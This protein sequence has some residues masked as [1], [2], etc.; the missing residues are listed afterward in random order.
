[1]NF[2]GGEIDAKREMLLL[3]FHLTNFD[4]ITQQGMSINDFE[5]EL[6]LA[7]ANSC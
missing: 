6:H 5:I 3:D 4:G 1:M 2:L 7:F